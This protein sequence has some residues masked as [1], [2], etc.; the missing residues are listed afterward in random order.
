MF[1]QLR[2]EVTG[3]WGSA[4]L[5]VRVRW[6]ERL[7]DD[8][9]WGSASQSI[10]GLAQ[11][12]T[13]LELSAPAWQEMLIEGV[14][15]SLRAGERGMLSELCEGYL[16]MGWPG[17]SDSDQPWVMASV[18]AQVHDVTDA[19]VGAHL[20][21]LLT[22]I[23]TR[24]AVGPY[25]AAHYREQRALTEGARTSVMSA[26]IWRFQRAAAL[27]TQ[28][29]RHVFATHCTLRQGVCGLLSESAANESRALLK[30]LEL[31]ALSPHEQLWYAL[32]M[33]HSEF[34]L[35]RVRAADVL[36]DLGTR[37]AAHRPGE[38][39]RVLSMHVL[40]QGLEW[41]IERD[42]GAVQSA[43]V[44]RLRGVISVVYQGEERGEALEELLELREV[45]ASDEGA[46]LEESGELLWR[47]WQR[48][49]VMGDGWAQSARAARALRAYILEEKG[50]EN[51]RLARAEAPWLHLTQLSFEVLE[52]CQHDEAQ[53]V[54]RLLSDLRS[55]IQST[56]SPP[57]SGTM[58]PFFATLPQLLTW[59][60]GL[61]PSPKKRRKLMETLS[62][63]E[64]DALK[65]RVQAYEALGEQ[66]TRIICLMMDRHVPQPSYG[67]WLLGAHLIEH[68][69]FDA[70]QV[71]VR[72]ALAS[73]VSVDEKLEAYVM[74]HMLY[75]AS[76][77]QS[78]PVMMRQWLEMCESA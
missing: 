37:V 56:I 70:A 46:S 71:V 36:D 23:Y 39:A 32:G 1:D 10:L 7:L 6:I 21:D 52:A 14:L 24:C 15:A 26:N 22:K 53:S 74:G 29:S 34:W 64:G 40:R 50:R 38:V 51:V 28:A 58:R 2:A 63:Q 48:S 69:L 27:A 3:V 68:D 44:D 12:M 47:L 45:L 75:W 41:M 13:T 49:D 35:D 61:V 65:V 60:G 62:E 9:Q 59:W 72:S 54:A 55:T 19:R 78:D 77:T 25:L 8:A 42:R 17:K 18:C 76:A 57:L 4:Q 73:R 11:H 16:W 33:A 66:I 43:E 30:S 5:E 67:W 31:P 20:G